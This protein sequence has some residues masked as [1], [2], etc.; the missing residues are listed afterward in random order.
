MTVAAKIS[1]NIGHSQ[2]PLSAILRLESTFSQV[3]IFLERASRELL[4]NNGQIANYRR[5]I[6]LNASLYLPSR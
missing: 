1:A 2:A 5:V 6:A 3:D 4:R